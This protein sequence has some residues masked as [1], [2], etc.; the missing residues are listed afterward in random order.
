MAQRGIVAGIAI[1]S[2]TIVSGCGSD[3]PKATPAVKVA[4]AETPTGPVYLAAFDDGVGAVAAGMTAPIWREPG[5]VAAMGGTAVYSVRRDGPD[6]ADRLVGIDPNTGE[7]TTSWALPTRGFSIDAVAP[8]HQWIA[9]TDRAPGYGSQGRASTDVVVV[10][11][12]TGA[13]T[14]HLTVAADVQPEAFST[15]GTRLFVLH[16]LVDHYRVQTIELGT[17]ARYDTGDRNKVL[18]PEDM[19]G[20][21]IHGVPSKDGTLLATLYRNP[22]E[23]DEPAFVHVLDLQHGWSYCADLPAPFGTGAPGTDAIERTSND[24]VVVAATDANRLAEIRIDEVR[25]PSD[26]PVHVSYRDGTITT[27]EATFRSI[28]GFDYVIGAIAS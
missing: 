25:T 28:S 27:P 12:S 16:Y 21:A 2:L 22:G 7:V 10:D 3:T 6:G 9:L 8:K 23:A 20:H 19:H 15:D 18:P 24:T 26:K 13:V 5:G 1:L 14:H 4:E 17:G 11:P